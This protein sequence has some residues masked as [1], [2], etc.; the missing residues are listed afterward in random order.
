V[1]DYFVIPKAKHAPAGAFEM[2]CALSIAL[3]LRVLATIDFDDQLRGK[4]GE[5]GEVRRHGMLSTK[6]MARK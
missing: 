3:G 6:T 5:V 4:A 1:L 2:L